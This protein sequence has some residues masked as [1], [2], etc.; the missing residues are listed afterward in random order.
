MV[1]SERGR[2]RLQ[3]GGGGARGC[4]TTTRRGMT[5]GRG[6]RE[7]VFFFP[8]LFAFRRPSLSRAPPFDRGTRR[9]GVEKNPVAS[10]MPSVHIPFVGRGSEVDGSSGARPDAARRRANAADPERAGVPRGDPVRAEDASRARD[11][12]TRFAS[13]RAPRESAQPPN[14]QLQALSCAKKPPFDRSRGRT[15]VA[16]VLQ[17]TL[18]RGVRRG[19]LHHEQHLR[20]GAGRRGKSG[21]RG[22]RRRPSAGLDA[23][24]KRDDSARFPLAETIAM[25]HRAAL[26]VGVARAPRPR[27]RGL[28]AR[29]LRRTLSPF[30][31]PGL[32][33]WIRSCVLLLGVSASDAIASRVLSQDMFTT[34][35]VPTSSRAGDRLCLHARSTSARRAPSE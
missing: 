6:E 34:R 26:P 3:S 8:R 13:A 19:V 10:S 30:G 32:E 16:D 7:R 15:F 14:P 29:F 27:P 20:F 31:N 23:S 25:R 2:M 35:D 21:R 17:Q 24:G 5:K 18:R 1:R 33:A 28:A 12:E 9:K 4:V 22:V 11:A